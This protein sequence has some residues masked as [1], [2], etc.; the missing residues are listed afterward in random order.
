MWKAF[1]V[2]ILSLA[3]SAPSAPAVD[4][5]APESC[6][7]LNPAQ[8]KCTFTVTSASTS[9]TV[10]GAVGGGSWKVLVKRGKQKLYIKPSGTEPEPIAFRYEIGDKVMATAS[11]AGSW[12][13]A[14]HD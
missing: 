14:G 1:L 9:Q 8:P 6:L 5:K 3:L 11:A 2:A 7:A 13:L 12:V 10:T 4:L